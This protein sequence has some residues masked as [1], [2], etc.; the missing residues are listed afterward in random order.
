MSQTSHL[1]LE[2]EDDPGMYFD[3]SDAG[4]MIYD[5]YN[6][7]QWSADSARQLFKQPSARTES[8]ITSRIHLW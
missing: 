8:T 2:G 4:L 7:C 5:V 1:D 6:R 3:S